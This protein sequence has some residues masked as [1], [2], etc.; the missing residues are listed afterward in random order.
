MLSGDLTLLLLVL[1]AMP[2]MVLLYTKRWLLSSA[3]SYWVCSPESSCV[4][5]SSF[6]MSN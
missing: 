4:V 1:F 5:Y 2:S 3:G 6:Q